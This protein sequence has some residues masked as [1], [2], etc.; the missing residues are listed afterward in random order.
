MDIESSARQ[1]DDENGWSGRETFASSVKIGSKKPILNLEEIEHHLQDVQCGDQRMRLHFVDASSARDARAACHGGHGGLGGLIITS[2][3]GCNKDGERAVYRVDDISY[4]EEGVALDLAVTEALWQ[5]AFD[6]IDINF[7][8]SQYDHIYRRHS[9]FSRARRKRQDNL[10]VEIPTDTPDDVTDVTFDLSSELLDTTFSA[11]DFLTGIDSLVP[12]SGVA[13]PD[14]PIEIGCKNCSTRGQ[15]ILTQGAINI[16]TKQIDL[17]PDIFEGGD[18]GKEINSIITGGYM[19]LAVT[20]VGARLEMFAHPVSSGSYEIALFPLP[21]LGFVIPGIGQ[22]GASFEPKISV[23]FEIDGELAVNY[24]FD[25]AIPDGAGIKV[26]LGDLTN[27]T[28]TGIKGTTLNALPFTS[29]A[30]DV[31][32]SLSLAFAPTIPIGFDFSDKLS[33]LVT[34]SMNLPRLDARLTTNAKDRCSLFDKGNKTKTDTKA[35]PKGADLSSLVLVE[36][37]V[38]VAI[39]VSADLTLPLLPAPFDSAG[40]SAQVF[41]T[42]MPLMTSCVTPVK[43]KLKIT[44]MP[45]VATIAADKAEVKAD[46]PCTCATATTTVYAAPPTGAPPPLEMT[47]YYPKAPP[48]ETPSTE[49]EQP[50]A[51]TALE[52]TPYYPV[53]TPTGGYGYGPSGQQPSP[54]PSCPSTQTVRITISTPPASTTEPPAPPPILIIPA[55]KP[56]NSTTPATT[57]L[58]PHSTTTPTSLPSSSSQITSTCTCTSKSPSASTTTTAPPKI[59]ESKGFM[60]PPGSATDT[61]TGTGSATP[62]STRAPDFTGAA[63][64]GAGVPALRWTGIVGL[65]LGVGV[66]MA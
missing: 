38:S 3:E 36:A 49:G 30:T 56:C 42:K 57:I 18:D 51:S 44:E 32:L 60:A 48:V 26:E 2:H 24:G 28:I 35:K 22:A 16:N 4:A 25:V 29:S 41:S 65:G 64:R 31:D 11:T 9:D 17:V 61:D 23:D 14:P 19:D 46:K 52:M 27:T 6:N 62:T 34:V 66:L 53:D 8:H 54:S 7:G 40:T 43:G 63:D 39:D 37:N 33:A 5:D 1:L 13:V 58:P 10:T 59:E 20:G 45:P 15:I 55:S 47:P 21:I 50:P 12:V